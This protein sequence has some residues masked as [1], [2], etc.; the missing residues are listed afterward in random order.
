MNQRGFWNLME[1]GIILGIVILAIAP[2]FAKANPHGDSVLHLGGA[3]SWLGVELRDVSPADVKAQK[4][5]GEYG[6]V[7]ASVE[8]NSPAAKAGLESGDVLVE[9]AGREIWSVSELQRRVGDTPAGRTVE[10]KFFRNGVLK[11]AS[12]TLAS[13]TRE[14]QIPAINFP[15]IN[16]PDF[17]HFRFWL[18]HGRLGIKGQDLTPQLASYF[19][20]A[21]GKGVLVM[22]VQAGSPAEK[23]GLRAGDSIIRFGSTEVDSLADLQTA[24]S[25]A[26]PQQAAELT[27]VRNH[28]QKELKIFLSTA[29]QPFAW[30]SDVAFEAIR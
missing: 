13:H 16:I 15:S 23:A 26:P 3:S 19:G 10:I 30:P 29:G 22:E 2:R 1:L 25:K 11:S 18:E 12:V 17:S 4:L 8:D 28:R 21:Q 24:I 5:P 7:V 6:A 14:L 27:I 9:F 20:V